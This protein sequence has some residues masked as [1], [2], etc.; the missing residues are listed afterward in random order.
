MDGL[1]INTIITLSPAVAVLLYIVYRQERR[2]DTILEH[3]LR[4]CEEPDEEE[5]SRS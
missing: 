4:Y 1:D 5:E 2:I 3:L